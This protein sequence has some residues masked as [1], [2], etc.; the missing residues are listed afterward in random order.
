MGAGDVEAMFVFHVDDIKVAATEKATEVVACALN[1]RF[2]TKNLGEVE[3]YMG[4][5]SK[6]DREKGTL[7]IS[8]TQFIQSALNRFSVSKFN[9]IPAT[10]S[11]YLRHVSEEETV[12]DVRF[13]EIVGSLMWIANQTKPDI[14]NAVRPV[15]R[16][17]HDPKPIHYEGA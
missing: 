6:R 14:A 11:L 16:F 9:P 17:S 10:S 4:S 5:E 13:R 1:Q 7:K 12:V 15:A 2:P 3:W 8:Q